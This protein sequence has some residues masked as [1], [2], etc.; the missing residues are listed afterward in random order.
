MR[1]I[2]HVAKHF[3]MPGENIVPNYD[4]RVIVM[5]DEGKIDRAVFFQKVFFP[6]LRYLEVTRHELMDAS[7]AE[8]RTEASAAAE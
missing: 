6:C 3:R 7:A 1:D 5:R 4:E 2:A 8:R